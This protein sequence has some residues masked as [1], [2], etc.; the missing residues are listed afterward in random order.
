MVSSKY[1]VLSEMAAVHIIHGRGSE[2]VQGSYEAEFAESFGCEPKEVLAPVLKAARLRKVVGGQKGM[3]LQTRVR[4]IVDALCAEPL[5][6]G[7]LAGL[8]SRLSADAFRQCLPLLAPSES[9]GEP[10]KAAWCALMLD[11]GPFWQGHSHL[12]Q[13]RRAAGPARDSAACECLA[14][15]LSLEIRKSINE[16]SFSSSDGS[17]IRMRLQTVVTACTCRG[18]ILSAWDVF[19][20]TLR[21]PQFA[22]GLSAHELAELHMVL[23]EL[24]ETWGMLMLRFWPQGGLLYEPES[25][26]AALAGLDVAEDDDE[27]EDHDAHE[28]DDEVPAVATSVVACSEHH[29][30]A[31]I[32]LAA[33]TLV[34]ILRKLDAPDRRKARAAREALRLALPLTVDTEDVEAD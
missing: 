34:R 6:T 22:A 15:S 4:A 7:S 28:V 26:V 16:A 8:L 20:A 25:I 1:D 21:P 19:L 23:D 17:N 32:S 13:L 27:G 24:V 18:E 30:V 11:Q 10:A 5:E 14:A 29:P 9:P 12:N 3:R 2:G 31:V 33:A